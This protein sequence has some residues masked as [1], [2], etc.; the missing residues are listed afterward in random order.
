M[1]LL[2]CACC[3][4]SLIAGSII[5]LCLTLQ[6]IY[7]SKYHPKEERY[8][9]CYYPDYGN[10]FVLSEGD[11]RVEVVA[12]VGI[13][14]V[15]LAVNLCIEVFSPVGNLVQAARLSFGKVDIRIM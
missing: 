10:C 6:S 5:L 14:M 7:N 4:H 2:P 8:N 12:L 9:E 3:T 15:F 1:P 13:S 11:R